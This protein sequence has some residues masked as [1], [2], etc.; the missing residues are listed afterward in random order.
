MDMSNSIWWHR[1]AYPDTDDP[2]GDDSWWN[3]CFQF[4][5]AHSIAEG[6]WYCT[7][8]DDGKGYV[9]VGR[10]PL[11]HGSESS[12]GE[13][14]LGNAD[15]QA[16]MNNVY[17]NFADT[18]RAVDYICFSNDNEDYTADVQ[19]AFVTK[20][21][22]INNSVA[23]IYFTIDAIM[24]YQKFFCFGPSLVLRDMEYNEWNADYTPNVANMNSQ[25]EDLSIQDNDFIFQH[26]FTGDSENTEALTYCDLGFYNKQFLTSDVSLDQNDI[27]PNAYYGGIPSFKPA[28]STK[29]GDIELGIGLY[30][31]SRD[32]N[33][34][35]L[36]LLGS[37][38]AMEH[39]LNSYVVP[40]KITNVTPGV[41][42]F[43]PDVYATITEGY[44]HD[45]QFEIH[46]PEG[47]NDNL[48]T[49]INASNDGYKP[50][51][52]K[53]HTAPF[54]YYS[55]SDKQG[56][57]VEIMPQELNNITPV[58]GRSLFDIKFF[59]ELTI[60]PNVPSCMYITNS[61]L[62][63]GSDWDPFMTLWQMPAYAMTP[64]NS[65]YNQQIIQGII[66]RN[67]GL[68]MAGIGIV[69]GSFAGAMQGFLGGAGNAV[70][71]LPGA[72]DVPG[73][74][75]VAG[76][77]SGSLS[78]AF[79]PVT[80]AFGQLQGFGTSQFLS[81]FMT[82]SKAKANEVYGLP[83]VAGG[84]PQGFT[85]F[86]MNNPGY[87][88]FF[89]HLKTDL[90]K[91]YD[92]QL[93]V[94]GYTQNKFRYPHIN[95]RKRW[96]FVQLGN[97]NM[98][99]LAANNY[100]NAGV[101]FAMRQQI[102]ERLAAGI[103]FWNMRYATTGGNDAGR[104]TITDYKQIPEDALYCHWIKN[105]GDGPDSDECVMNRD[106]RTYCPDYSD[107]HKVK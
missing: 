25:P 59:L 51:N 72:K 38:N 63:K 28:K 85:Q 32:I 65:G 34:P 93:S 17:A 101:P 46:F 88:F 69:G 37:F 80:Q 45:K 91:N 39:I 49:T 8:L 78:G 2:R 21:A 1:F 60:A 15:K 13:P 104:S 23:R 70:Q 87:E 14:G 96:T 53:I 75:A 90:I 74:G 94:M 19:Y 68:V 98:I 42:A 7:V 12:D 107:E 103:T 48:E 86:V 5:K 99:P 57:S 58:A 9:D 105:Y 97:V 92:Y 35:V 3:T 43:I 40:S 81:S 54:T 30:S 50:L 95:T 31:S 4:F 84:L 16:E 33:D 100:D 24:T 64:N 6:N 52:L 62:I 77:I 47:F 20:I 26:I 73:L 61:K 22:R 56:S 82:R 102:M 76:A 44:K 79:Q 11:A 36:T 18:I 71:A 106:D 27:T 41:T 83:K 29:S 89:C 67:N 55:I 10:T 66:Q